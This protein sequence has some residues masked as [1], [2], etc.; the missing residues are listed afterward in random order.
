MRPSPRDHLLGARQGAHGP[1]DPVQ[2]RGA[3]LL[4]TFTALP[5]PTQILGHLVVTED[6]G[7]ATDQFVR[8]ALSNVVDGEPTLVLGYPGMEVH[9]K[10]QVTEFFTQVGVGTLLH[11]VNHLTGFLDEMRQ[12]RHM[13]LFSVPGAFDAQPRHHLVETD[14]LLAGPGHQLSASTEM[15]PPMGSK[16][17]SGS[18]AP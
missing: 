4:L 11:R 3:P 14:Q 9:L 17:C 6:V 10:Q 18:H 5:D 12:Q 13:G 7:V 1:G 8:D 16:P 2:R 15:D